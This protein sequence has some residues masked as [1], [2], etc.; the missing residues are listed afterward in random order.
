[1]SK[2]WSDILKDKNSDK[3]SS[4]KFLG[5]IG[6]GLLFLLFIE[7]MVMMWISDKIDYVLVGEMIGFVLTLFGFKNV[8]RNGINPKEIEKK[9]DDIQIKLEDTPPKEL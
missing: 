3:F 8:K 1:M 4:T 9:I 2:F 5:L 6:G 7:A